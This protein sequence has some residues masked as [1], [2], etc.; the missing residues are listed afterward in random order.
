M[1]Y[2]STVSGGG[3][4]GAFISSYLNDANREKVGLEAGKLPFAEPGHAEPAPLRQL[5]NNSKYLLKGG[6]LGQSRMVGLMLLGILINLLTLA[7]ILLGTLALAKAAQIVGLDARSFET[8]VDWTLSTFGL[9][10]ALMVLC[11][12]LV[13][14]EWAERPDWIARYEGFGICL[15][16]L[17]LGFWSLAWLMPWLYQELRESL[18][19]KV[20]VVA[21]FA[22]LP[23]LFGTVAFAVGLAGTV[24]RLMV[25]AVGITGPLLL[26]MAFYA[27]H[28]WISPD[29]SEVLILTLS[30]V[31]VT[32]W[33]WF[34]NVNQ[35][36]PHRY[37]RNRLAETYLIR[38]EDTDG[39]PPAP[40]PLSKLRSE[41]PAAPYHLINAAVNLPGSRESELRG[42]NA[43]F[44]LFSQHF[45]GSPLLGY[46]KTR[47]LE[48]RDLH[49]DLATAMAISGAAAS[50]HMGTVTIKG[51]SFWL[52]LLNV[53]LAYWLPNPKRLADLPEKTAGRPFALWWE[54]FGLM[55]EN[56]RFVNLSDG[57]H[58]ENLGIYE[59]MRRRCKFIIAI[60]GEADPHMRFP[61]L[62]KLI[63]FAQI[64][65]GIRMDI[66][67]GDLQ[68]NADGYSKAH[69]V[70]G[71]I[72]YG[73]DLEGYLLYI[74]SSL[75]G[76]ERDYVLDYERTHPSFPH[77]TTAD[78]FFDEAQFEA[79]RALGNHIG[80][81][82]M[83]AELIGQKIGAISLE[84][85]FQSL[86]CNLLEPQPQEPAGAV[87]SH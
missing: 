4:F 23:V 54:M 24:G 81:D 79:Y 17:L 13:Y 85:W 53:R 9:A 65:F 80:R 16:L 48:R 35:V 32:V 61:S 6:L 75:T 29:G 50:S 28:D 42:R 3:Y 33:L 66:N 34:I 68:K 20:A 15:A 26:L 84:D 12:P 63:R 49:L 47:D 11:L 43:D 86:V 74:K 71:T 82:L 59:L 72:D 52:A 37:Y 83:Q 22:A 25:S 8:A 30:G 67:L 27:L 60:D 69:F 41:N 10:L 73:D 62:M 78:Q 70:L 1:D 55:G 36:S 38:E 64:D 18:G 31:V 45:C 77:E 76:N 46:C 87:P 19:S 51:L 56:D 40:Q 21:L 14:R 2:L 39:G 57:G 7:P 58:I 5:R 44:F